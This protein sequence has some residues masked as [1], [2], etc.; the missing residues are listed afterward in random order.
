MISL[1]EALSDLPLIAVLRGVRPEEAAAIGRALVESG[2]RLIE[3]TLNSFNPFRSIEILV[4]ECGKQAVIGAGTVTRPSEA[5]RVR[6]AGGRLVVM[7]HADVEVIRAAK[8]ADAWCIPGTATPTEAI[9]ALRAGADA[10]KLFP[11]EVLPPA[12]LK[13]WSAVLPPGTRLMPVGGITPQSMDAYVEAG[14][15]GFG[16]GSALYKPG[17]TPEDITRRAGGFVTAWRAA[18]G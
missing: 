2:F 5:D 7:P 9:A 4:D 15:A 1:D 8:A 3:V 13:A 10:L 18:R 12:V 6:D 16:I 17:V 14:A 11:A